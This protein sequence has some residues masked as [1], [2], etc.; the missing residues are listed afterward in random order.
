[1][2]VRVGAAYRSV[3]RVVMVGQP[4]SVGAAC[5]H[6]VKGGVGEGEAQGVAHEGP[7]VQAGP[8]GLDLRGPRLVT[9][10]AKDVD[11]AR[12]REGVKNAVISREVAAQDRD[13]LG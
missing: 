4:I 6:P 13:D 12:A 10:V 8:L 7:G 9:V 5:S 11:A 3:L 2:V 1:E